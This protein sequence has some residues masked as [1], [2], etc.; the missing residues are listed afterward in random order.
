MLKLFHYFKINGFAIVEDDAADECCS[1][2][3]NIFSEDRKL[4]TLDSLFHYTGNTTST[5]LTFANCRDMFY[6]YKM[7]QI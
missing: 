4:W 6:N 2:I 7:F 1:M 3:W 5:F